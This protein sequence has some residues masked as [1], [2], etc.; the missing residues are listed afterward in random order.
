MS[1]RGRKEIKRGKRIGEGT[2]RRRKTKGL[3]LERIEEG[4][5][6]L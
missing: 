1:W 2:R 6:R 4:R 3:C 5:E